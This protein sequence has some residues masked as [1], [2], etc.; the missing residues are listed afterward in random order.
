MI[1]P[2]PMKDAKTER[3]T[4]KV[5][6]ACFESICRSLRG[7]LGD[8]KRTK[9]QKRYW[10]AFAGRLLRRRKRRP[11]FRQRSAAIAVVIRELRAHYA[12][13]EAA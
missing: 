10:I 7:K 11:N 3:K 1:S 8:V 2:V 6:A 5:K 13:K 9:Q 4:G 12:R